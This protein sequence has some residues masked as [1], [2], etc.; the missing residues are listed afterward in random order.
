M[1]IFDIC[2]YIWLVLLIPALIANWIHFIWAETNNKQNIL[3]DLIDHEPILCIMVGC[4]IW[5]IIPF[6]PILIPLL[7][8]GK[9][10][11]LVTEYT[12]KKLSKKKENLENK[13]EDKI[14]SGD[15]RNFNRVK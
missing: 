8:F 5:A 12:I 11:I 14:E 10:Y 6:S 4:F 2:L 9:G 15:Y 3:S 13:I 7:L 1:K